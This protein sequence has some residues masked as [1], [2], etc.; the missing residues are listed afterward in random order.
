MADVELVESKDEVKRM[1]YRR[2]KIEVDDHEYNAT[3]WLEGDFHPHLT[4]QRD[5]QSPIILYPD[6]LKAL[7]ALFDR[8]ALDELLGVE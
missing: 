7:K 3:V 4:F 2:Y 8:G 1:R 6:D 5:R